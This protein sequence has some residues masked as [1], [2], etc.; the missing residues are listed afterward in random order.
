MITIRIT[1][2]NAIVSLDDA[3]KQITSGIAGQDDAAIIQDAIDRH[4]DLPGGEVRLCA[5]KYRLSSPIQVSLPVTITGEGR[6]TEIMPPANDFAFK[7]FEDGK[8]PS[9]CFANFGTPPVHAEPDPN[10]APLET[11]GIRPRLH[12]VHIRHLAIQGHGQGRGIYLSCLTESCFRDLWIMNTADGAALYFDKEVM[13]TIFENLHLSNCGSP[14]NRE[15]AIVMKSQTGDACN[16]LHFRSVYVIFP[17]YIGIEIGGDEGPNHPRLLWFEN[18]MV[19]G[20]H[21]RAEPAPYDLVR[22]NRTDPT[23]S[24]CFRGC[25]LTNGGADNAFLRVLGGRVRIEDSVLGGGRGKYILAA[26][27]G[28]A[29]QAVNNTFH[30]TD[31]LVSLMT[32]EQAE[33]V[34]SG[35]HV[36]L[37]RGEKVVDISSPVFARVN[38]NAFI[39]TDGQCP[40]HLS[41]SNDAPAGPM[42]V[43]GN[44]VRGTKEIIRIRLTSGAVVTDRENVV[45]KQGHDSPM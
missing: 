9:R 30:D 27:P 40:I 7:V 13:E 37:R 4:T 18:C 25:R 17:Q 35:N 6:A 43:T 11:Y 29:L 5:G 22:V 24:I 16:N 26:G 23:R 2:E 20:W 31:D 33:V 36:V 44:F 42:A 39:L 38:E 14:A 1:S 34:F 19:H 3:G 8:C 15:A 12:S 21:C 32:A 41:D 45:A 28:A 10:W